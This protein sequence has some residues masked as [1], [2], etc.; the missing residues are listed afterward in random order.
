MDLW[1]LTGNG[2]DEGYG[3]RVGLIGIFDSEEQAN[4][5][6]DST[7]P[8]DLFDRFTEL[9][10]NKVTLNKVYGLEVHPE[11]HYNKTDPEI[12]LGGYCE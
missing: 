5:V 12:Y 6:K 9:E 7:N 1:I 11:Y 3:S 8:N 2:Y 10:L 4:V